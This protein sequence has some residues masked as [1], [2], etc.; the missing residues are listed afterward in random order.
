VVARFLSGIFLWMAKNG[1]GEEILKF[2]EDAK[3]GLRLRST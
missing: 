3:A 1:G 2:V